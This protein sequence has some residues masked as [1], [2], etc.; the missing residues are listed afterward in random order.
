MFYFLTESRLMQQDKC[1]NGNSQAKKRENYDLFQFKREGLPSYNDESI[2][3]TILY[4]Y[5]VL[6]KLTS[7][8]DGY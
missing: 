8:A 6:N 2:V 1:C 7:I 4:I 5:F 3:Q